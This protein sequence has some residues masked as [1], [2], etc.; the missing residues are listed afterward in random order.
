MPNSEMGEHTQRKKPRSALVD[1]LV[2]SPCHKKLDIPL[3]VI[4]ELDPAVNGPKP[5]GSKH[6]IKNEEE[7]TS[8]LARRAN[9]LLIRQKGTQIVLIIRIM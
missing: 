6:P 2:Y 5:P 9:Y 4:Q 7:I 3:Q 1:F 8:L